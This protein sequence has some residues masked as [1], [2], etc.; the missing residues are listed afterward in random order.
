MHADPVKS[1]EP[2]IPLGALVARVNAR[3]D[4]RER[5]R[6]AGARR[7]ATWPGLKPISTLAAAAAALL[8]VVQPRA[9]QAPPAPGAQAGAGA[10]EVSL[11][12]DSLRRLER[13]VARAQAARYLN[14]AQDVLVTVA[15]SLPR[16]ERKRLDVG[17]EARRSRD[18]LARRALLVELDE[19]HVGAAGP[20]L[21]DVE[22]VLRDVAALD[23][24]ARP[25]ELEAIHQDLQDRRLLMRMS[26]IERELV[27]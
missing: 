14:E 18:L 9:P 3:L 27:G 12:A 26:L 17:Q 23:P 16:C 13:D 15:A 2:P 10:T 7:W 24:C 20:V 25:A 1:A 5:G 4:E 21:Q 22:R 6:A 8:A 19:R 11:P